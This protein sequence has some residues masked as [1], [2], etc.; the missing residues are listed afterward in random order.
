MKALEKKI[1]AGGGK[2]E[3]KTVNGGSLWVM[4][5]RIMAD[6]RPGRIC[7]LTPRD[8][9]QHKKHKIARVMPLL[10]IFYA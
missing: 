6:H 2:A 7:K 4:A 8:K 1:K 10:D 9:G 5:N 3:L